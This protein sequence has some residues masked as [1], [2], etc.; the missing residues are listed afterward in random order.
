MPIGW[1]PRN[2]TPKRGTLLF[3]WKA[4]QTPTRPD[5][6]EIPPRCGIIRTCLLFW[7]KPEDGKEHTPPPTTSNFH[8]PPY[9]IAR[10][11]NMNRELSLETA[12]RLARA[13]GVTVDSLAGD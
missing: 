5:V 12:R 9:P 7:R 4:G 6:H 1:L 11:A 10:R 2:T 8:P 13:L 3:S